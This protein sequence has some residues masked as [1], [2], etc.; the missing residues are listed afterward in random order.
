MIFYEDED[1]A[2]QVAQISWS[3]EAKFRLPVAVWQKMMDSYYPNVAWL[4]LRRDVFD[5]LHRYK[6]DNGIPTW[7]QAIESMLAATKDEALA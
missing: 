2:L 6:I 7:E 5:K 4:T 1:G 3:K